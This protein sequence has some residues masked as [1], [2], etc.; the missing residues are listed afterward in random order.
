MRMSGCPYFWLDKEA[1][2]PKMER[3]LE[4]EL[5]EGEERG[6]VYAQADFSEE[7]C[8]LSLRVRNIGCR[9]L[10]M[11]SPVWERS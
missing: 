2:E 6:R 5:M 11:I 4:P 8:V 1:G 9:P 7:P 10:L 3:I